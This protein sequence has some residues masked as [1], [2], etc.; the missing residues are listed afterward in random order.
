[1][2]LQPT[3]FSCDTLAFLLSTVKFVVSHH[4]QDQFRDLLSPDQIDVRFLLCP[5]DWDTRYW[6]CFAWLLQ[7]PHCKKYNLRVQR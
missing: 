6:W 5:N 2:L 3:L 7:R 4:T 1:M